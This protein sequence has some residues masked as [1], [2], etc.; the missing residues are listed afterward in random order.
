MLLSHRDTSANQ[1]K[2]WDKFKDGRW[3][4]RKCTDINALWIFSSFT[5]MISVFSDIPCYV[6]IQLWG[7]SLLENKKGWSPQ[8]RLVLYNEQDAQARSA[9]SPGLS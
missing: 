8:E 3:M 6:K 9:C 2:S 7:G 1:C 4:R 5:N